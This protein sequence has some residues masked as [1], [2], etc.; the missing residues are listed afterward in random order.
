MGDP[1]GVGP[2]LSLKSLQSAKIKKIAEPIIIGDWGLLNKLAQKLKIKAPKENQVI[3]LSNLNLKAIKAGK[4]TKETSKAM[5]DYITLGTEMVL[6]GEGHGLVTAP[7]SKAASKLSGFKFPGHTEYLASLTTSGKKENKPVMM[8]AGSTLKV[9]LVTI[10][11]ALKNVPK[12]IT[13]KN[14]LDTIKIT[15]QSLKQYF[16]IKHPKIAVAG[17]NPHAGE[18]GLFGKEEIDSITPAIK[19]ARRAGINATGPYPADTVFFRARK[20]EFDVV[21]AMYHDQGLA[22]LKLIHFDNG[23][24][25]TLGL[26]IVRTSPDH[27]TAYDI[28]WTGKANC[29]SMFYAIE[30][31]TMMA[32]RKS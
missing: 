9:V 2:E 30:T 26:P 23:V 27:G 31:A 16:G 29:E 1:T 15:N 21:I 22:P 7:I 8:L 25:V 4:P 28:A 14:V 12:L 24:N 5:I 3:N 13:E 18:D 19:K 6:K 10:H 17:L 32:R 11:V 20:S